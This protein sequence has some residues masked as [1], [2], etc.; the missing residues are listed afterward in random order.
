MNLGEFS[1]MRS[2]RASL[3]Y[4]Q[5]VAVLLGMVE[6]GRHFRAS[7]VFLSPCGPPHPE[8]APNCTCK[9]GQI[10]C[11]HLSLLPASGLASSSSRMMTDH[12]FP[13]KEENRKWILAAEI[14]EAQSN[15][16]LQQPSPAMV[17]S[18]F[19]RSTESLLQAHVLEVS[20]PFN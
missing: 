16:L 14:Q 1:L 10:C 2:P 7:L 19:T 20:P 11:P 17:S 13:L 15:Q 3:R 12:L 5:P 4:L 18:K 9:Q 6:E 8:S